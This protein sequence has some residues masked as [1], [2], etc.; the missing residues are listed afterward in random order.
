MATA[1]TVT[2]L[3]AIRFFAAI[4]L[5]AATPNTAALL[6]ELLPRRLRSQILAAVFV[7]FPLGAALNGVLIPV[8]VP[9]FGWRTMI[10]VGAA[11]P[12]LLLV[13][14]I[15]WVPESPSFLAGRPKRRGELVELLNR[16]DERNGFSE[17]DN[18]TVSRPAVTHV[19]VRALL[20]RTYLRD[21][22]CLWVVGFSN[23]FAG[24]SLSSWA[25]TAL[26]A[27]GFGYF[28]AVN[29]LM[30]GNLAG[31]AGALV[32]GWAMARLGSRRSLRLFA[33]MGAATALTVFWWTSTSLGSPVTAAENAILFVAMA[34]I[35]ISTSGVQLGEY[36]L[37]TNIYPV[38][39]RASGVGFAVAV[40][41]FGAI[42]AVQVSG[43]FLN[44]FGE[45]FLFASV[46]TAIVV[47]LIALSLITRH[48][49][50]VQHMR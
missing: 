13:P 24:V 26:T 37:A 6:S 38:T 20:S 9:D 3:G 5:G 17:H 50:R 4:G 21:T 42:S 29:G 16:L 2:L 44:T 11:L 22:L 49:E 34:L 10:V 7:G 31:A 36:P 45:Q 43:Y 39:F 40:G 47:T 30:A 14:L 1:P 32:G 46:G 28:T 18:F 48:T 15:R 23:Q 25:T 19:G 27:I 8:I 33:V 12:L 35:G 41:R